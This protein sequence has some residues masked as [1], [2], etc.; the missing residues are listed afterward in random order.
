MAAQ[1][2]CQVQ[3]L[4]LTGKEGGEG[5]TEAVCDRVYPE[6]QQQH[7]DNVAATPPPDMEVILLHH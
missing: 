4:A 2:V 7:L 3:S 6:P 1:L 5:V